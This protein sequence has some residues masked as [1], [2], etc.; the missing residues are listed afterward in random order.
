MIFN[1]IN[2]N[3]VYMKTTL[4]K[5]LDRIADVF[6]VFDFSFIISG[7]A[8][9]IMIYTFLSFSYRETLLLIDSNNSWIF[10]IFIIYI[11]GL[12]MFALGRYIRQEVFGQTKSKY[13]LFKK[14]GFSSESDEEIDIL[15]SQYWNNLRSDSNE[16]SY[17]YYN[18]LWVMTAVYEG[19]AGSVI[20]AFILI[21][22]C[23]CTIVN[24]CGWLPGILLM[25]GIFLLI[26]LLV[27]ILFREAKKNA[28]TIIIDLIARNRH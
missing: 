4:N 22:L 11:L 6:S 15:F 26:C 17:D 23:F 24:S 12:I 10:I 21:I 25:I 13:Q 7:M 27:S 20:L 1:D 8:A 19:L 28:E 5:I 16:K 9:F 2:Q 14:Y 18:R 3:F